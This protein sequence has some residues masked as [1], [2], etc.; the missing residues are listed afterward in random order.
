MKSKPEN[1]R[2]GALHVLY[3]VE[4]EGAYVNLALAKILREDSFDSRDAALLTQLVYG[5]LRYQA[6]LDY[7]LGELLRKPPD[8]FPLWIYLILRLSLYQLLFLD[9][10]PPS[11]AVNEGVKLAK[12]YGHKGT[13]SLV[14]AVLRNFLRSKDRL[15]LPTKEDSWTDYL[16]LTL[17]HP[18]WL[19]AY[20]LKDWPESE[21][22]AFYNYNNSRDSITLRVNTLKI[23]RNQLI[24]DLLKL[25]IRAEQGRMAPESL[26]LKGAGNIFSQS[27][28][29]EG[30]CTVQDQSSMLAAHALAPAKGSCVLDLCAAPGGKATHLAQL[31]EDQGEI[32]AIDIHPHKLKLIR[33]NCQRLGI[34]SITAKEGDSLEL[35]LEYQEWADYILLDAPCSGLGVLGSRPDLRWQKREQDIYTMAQLSASLL[36]QAAAYLKVGGT[37]LFSTCTI[38][39][40][41]NIQNIAGFL[42]SRPDFALKPL[43]NL[44]EMAF[45]QD[46][47]SQ[48]NKGYW[49]L[50]P[51][52]HGVD[53]FFLARLEKLR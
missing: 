43:E 49:Q 46:D 19:T 8:N 38:T 31:M 30:Y 53:G 33:D 25:G 10:I 45:D 12:K 23:S 28:F 16:N 48:L 35:P 32:H 34:N 21:I 9:K 40:E 3:D 1:A 47:L 37:L 36:L 52:K 22:E 14:N 17:S 39:K 7:Y 6:V 15:A 4:K 26:I 51:Q 11:A 29:K 5:T 24:K 50:L 41:E 20:L 13:V 44:T 27:V 18:A 2:E 42:E